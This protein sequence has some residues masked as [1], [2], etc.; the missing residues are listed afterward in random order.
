MKRLIYQVYVGPKSNLYDWCTNS[1]EQYA[2]DIGADY[3]LQTI[4]KL[5]LNQIPLLQIVVREHLV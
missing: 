3:I 5:L 1:V 4:P 2:K